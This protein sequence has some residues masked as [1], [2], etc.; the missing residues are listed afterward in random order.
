[1]DLSRSQGRNDQ[2]L[3]SLQELKG[4]PATPANVAAAL[5]NM[6]DAYVERFGQE[7]NLVK[8]GAISGKY[9]HDVDTYYAEAQRG[10]AS[11]V[12]VRDAFY[13]TAEQVLSTAYSAAR[14]SFVIALGGLFA[15]VIASVGLVTMVRRRVCK[16]IV[17]LT[18]TMSRLAG[19]GVPHEISGSDR[20]DAYSTMTGAR[21]AF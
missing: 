9:E 6:N 16:P 15:V 11:V 5:G 12:E 19:G 4:N 14:V 18:A 10:L 3:M 17:D 1:M 2:I 13:D 20:D 8:E 7:Q 21:P